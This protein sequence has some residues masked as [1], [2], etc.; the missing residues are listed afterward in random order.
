MYP[1]RTNRSRVWLLIVDHARLA[2]CA[3]AACATLVLSAALLLHGAGPADT[4]LRAATVFVLTYGA[5]LGFLVV[6]Q[7]AI[8][9]ALAREYEEVAAARRAAKAA[10]RAEARAEAMRGDDASE[11][12]T[13]QEA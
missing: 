7:R 2:A 6:Y 13:A 3:A 12:L 5:C 11:S 10:A 1:V 8:V 9:Y 4:V